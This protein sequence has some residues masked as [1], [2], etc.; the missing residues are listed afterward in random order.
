MVFS[1]EPTIPS[2]LEVPV[3]Q[4]A[5]STSAAPIYLPI[6]VVN[7]VGYVDGGIFA[8]NPA[9]VGLSR[10]TNSGRC[11]LENAVILSLGTGVVLQTID[12]G[13]G[14]PQWGL[15]QWM[16]LSDFTKLGQPFLSATFDAMVETTNYIAL[17]FLKDRYLRIQPA[18]P[19][20]LGAF[21]PKIIPELQRI[22]TEYISSQL[23]SILAWVEKYWEA[24]PPA[25]GLQASPDISHPSPHPHPI[26]NF[27]RLDT[28]ERA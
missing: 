1:N 27:L 7:N 20:G 14:F 8:N 28:A 19:P 15:D 22:A 11:T 18:L 21:D 9:L 23:S 5:L 4:A 12:S 16:S 3:V 10:A 17:N 26:S 25:Q 13:S 6:N 24:P 2:T